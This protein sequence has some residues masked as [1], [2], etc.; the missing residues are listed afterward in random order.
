[1]IIDF[2][3]CHFCISCHV[4]LGVML[5]LNEKPADILGCV[6]GFFVPLS[7]FEISALLFF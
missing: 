2:E 6:G 5:K 1:M 4:I 3:F 7:I